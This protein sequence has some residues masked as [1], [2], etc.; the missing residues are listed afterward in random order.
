MTVPQ[1]PT[2]AV[3]QRMEDAVNRHDVAAMM[4]VLTEDVVWETTQPPDGERHVGQAAVRAAGEAFFASS[5]NAVFETEEIVAL[6]D[7]AVS[8]WLFRWVDAEG[9]PGHVRGVDLLRVR[10]GKVAEILSYVKG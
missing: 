5:S 10:D 9:K 3:V 4:A 6:G 7:R 1:D 8:R 2:I